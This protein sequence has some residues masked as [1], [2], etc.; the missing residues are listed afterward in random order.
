MN[1]GSVRDDESVRS[2]CAC[3]AVRSSV[4]RAAIV[5]GEHWNSEREVMMRRLECLGEI[6]NEEDGC[7]DGLNSVLDGIVR[8]WKK[9]EL[10]GNCACHTH[11]I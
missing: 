8:E 1:E 6:P 10:Q 5:D 2:G 7:L 3:E 9:G 11:T 4:R